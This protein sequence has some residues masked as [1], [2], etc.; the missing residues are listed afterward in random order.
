MKTFSLVWF[1]FFILLSAS[2]FLCFFLLIVPLSLNPSL[3]VLV[4]I[5]FFFPLFVGVGNEA[6]NIAGW[7]FQTHLLRSPPDSCMELSPVFWRLRL[8]AVLTEPR[9]TLLQYNVGVL[10]SGSHHWAECSFSSLCGPARLV[11]RFHWL[12]WKHSFSFV[13]FWFFKKTVSLFIWGWCSDLHF[14]PPV[15]IHFL[16]TFGCCGVRF[17]LNTKTTWLRWQKVLISFKFSLCFIDSVSILFFITNHT[18]LTNHCIPKC[19]DTLFHYTYPTLW[20]LT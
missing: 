16:F 18:T 14:R 13:F 19:N 12:F 5:F 4:S 9:W 11:C 17:I 10:H 15:F 8:Q 20:K 6:S 1:Y 3:R 7:P 2:S